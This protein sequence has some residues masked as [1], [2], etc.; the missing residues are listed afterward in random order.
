VAKEVSG[1]FAGVFVAREVNF[2]GLVGPTHNYGG[3]SHGNLASQSNAASISRP[4]EAALQGLAKAKALA[5]QGLTQGMLPP[6]ERPFVPGLRAIGF[7]GD[8]GDALRAAWRT[9]PRLVTNAASS[10]HMWAAN[11][12]TVSPS[13]DTGDGRVHFTPANLVTMAHRAI[14]ADQ[15]ARSLRAIFANPELFCVHDPLPMH[16]LYGDEGAA[17]HM[18]L[19]PAF[20]APGVEIMVYGRDGFAPVA[21]G[22]PARQT[23]QAGEAIFRAHDLTPA[24]ALHVRQSKTAIEAGAFH[25]DVVAVASREVLFAHEHAFEDRERTY[26][27]IRRACAGLLELTVIEVP[28]SQ[29]PLA[30]AIK[31][32]LFNTQLVEVPGQPGL[33]LIAPMECAETPSVKA[34]LDANTGPNHPISRVQFVDVRQSMR[35][36]GGPACLR[37]RVVLSDAELAGLG[38]RCILD[39]G[40]YKDLTDWVSRHYREELTPPDLADP[41]LLGEA[42]SALRELVGIMALPGDFYPFLRG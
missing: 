2:D 9:D 13:A 5:D 19:A 3:L 23:L 31:S 33:V 40:L 30:D 17:N 26:Q 4:R 20:G 42:R 35:N 15:T 14:E 39:E 7:G 32:Y 11:A 28:E 38:A 12:A 16:A 27:D 8:D 1:S 29:V 34:W 18:R 37:L 6:H 10:A 41:A 21:P 22:F 24:R 36:G 25:N